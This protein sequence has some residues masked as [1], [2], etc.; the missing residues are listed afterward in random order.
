MVAIAIVELLGVQ[1]QLAGLGASESHLIGVDSARTDERGLQQRA[2]LRCVPLAGPELQHRTAQRV[3]RINLEGVEEGRAGGDH[4][5]IAVEQ[6]DGG[7]RRSNDRQRQTVGGFRMKR[8][9][10]G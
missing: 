3:G 7:G 9:R 2:Q 4:L 10:H 8:L 6:H 5:Q 1:H